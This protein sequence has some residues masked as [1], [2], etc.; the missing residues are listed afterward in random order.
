[1]PYLSQITPN[2]TVL[3]IPGALDYAATPATVNA[4]EPMIPHPAAWPY[5]GG[6]SWHRIRRG[7]AVI[8]VSPGR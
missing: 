1:M 2:L 7:P 4:A 5:T 6:M 8:P 3:P